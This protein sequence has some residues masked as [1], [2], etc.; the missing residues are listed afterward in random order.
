M[1]ALKTLF[2]DIETAPLLAHIWQPDDGYISPD[3]ILHDSFILCWSGKWA[4]QKRIVSGLLTGDEAKSQD[5]SRIVTDL[6][7]LLREADIV[8]GHNLDQFDI[9]MLNNRLLA[10][11]LEPLGPLRTL[12]TLTVARKSFRL[13]SNKL[14]YLARLLGLGGKLKTGFSLWRACYLGDE[15]ALAKMVRYNRRDVVLLEQV[16]D[17]LKPYA[18]TLPRLSEAE[19]AGERACPSCGS[20]QLIARGFYRTQASTYQKWRCK[21]CGRYSRA[22][23][24]ERNRFTV[25]PL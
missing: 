20:Y 9:P 22:R 11:R 4:G 16:F 19:R 7:D 3:R 8:V 13:A 1:P 24:A 14:D 18:K 21:N 2:F 6:A 10:L 5:D 17:R 15:K 25:H 23:T 12:D